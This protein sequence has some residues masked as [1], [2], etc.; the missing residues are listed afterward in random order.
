M[1]T[2][3]P[4]S[5]KRPWELISED[6]VNNS[7]NNKHASFSPCSQ[8]AS[9]TTHSS[10]P[11]LDWNY[12]KAIDQT[13]ADYLPTPFSP[14]DRLHYTGEYS[15]QPPLKGDTDLGEFTH[16][17]LAR[18]KRMAVSNTISHMITDPHLSAKWTITP[19]TQYKDRTRCFKEIKLGITPTTNHE[20]AYAQMC[21]IV[22]PPEQ[23]CIDCQAKKGKFQ[24]CVVVP[25]YLNGAC[26][27]CHYNSAGR[28]CSHRPAITKRPKLNDVSA[29]NPVSIFNSLV[30]LVAEQQTYLGE[31]LRRLEGML[32]QVLESSK[33]LEGMLLQVLESSKRLEG[34]LLQKVESSRRSEGILLQMVDVPKN[35]NAAYVPRYYKEQANL[36]S[37][38]PHKGHV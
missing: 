7:N 36:N 24:H 11:G 18:V 9:N 30:N 29:A 26:A 20:A 6:E 23:S 32:L 1:A 37:T 17:V 8:P 14:S 4:R 21:G 34:M 5:K 10:S 13:Q 25:G 33:R 15:D 19:N 16:W 2:T 31:M 38:Q 27:N 28:K 22:L 12:L 3:T 35:N